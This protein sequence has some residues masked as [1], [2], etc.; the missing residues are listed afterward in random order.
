[1]TC[2]CCSPAPGWKIG[3]YKQIEYFTVWGNGCAS[4]FLRGSSR[5]GRHAPD[6]LISG[7]YNAIS[8]LVYYLGRNSHLSTPRP[9]R[10]AT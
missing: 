1:M 10:I 6:R 3:L 7:H 4:G 5:K 2:R 8:S 9:S